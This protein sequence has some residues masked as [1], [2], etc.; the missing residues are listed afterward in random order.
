MG[1]KFEFFNRKVNKVNR[2][3]RSEGTNNGKI[4]VFFQC[5]HPTDAVLNTDYFSLFTFH[6][7]INILK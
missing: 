3:S 6:K 5:V 1:E 7:I 4:V 2:V